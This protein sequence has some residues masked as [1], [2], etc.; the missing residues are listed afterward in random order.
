MENA[1]ASQIVDLRCGVSSLPIAP[2]AADSGLFA[3]DGG[4]YA[5]ENRIVHA[6]NKRKRTNLFALSCFQGC[7][8]FKFRGSAQK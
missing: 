7:T 5:R 4:E 8:T 6:I 2:K 3:A 1:A